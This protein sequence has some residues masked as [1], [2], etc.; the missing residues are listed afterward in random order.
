MQVAEVG[1]F[2]QQNSI[3]QQIKD[4]LEDVPYLVASGKG[5]YSSVQSSGYES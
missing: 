4:W 5:V 3:Y 1:N 2:W